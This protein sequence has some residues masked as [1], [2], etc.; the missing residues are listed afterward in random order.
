ML[1]MDDTIDEKDVLIIIDGVNVEVQSHLW[2][3]RGR[4]FLKKTFFW[5][6][7]KI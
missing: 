6:F 3:S 7:L 5:F 1:N 4:L 2:Q